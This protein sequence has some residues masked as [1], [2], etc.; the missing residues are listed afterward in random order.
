MGS[1]SSFSHSINIPI[2]LQRGPQRWQNRCDQ[3]GSSHLELPWAVWHLGEHWHWPLLLASLS[4]C[5]RG[6]SRLAEACSGSVGG[7][8]LNPG[9]S[10][11]TATS[12]EELLTSGLIVVFSS[13]KPLSSSCH[14]WKT[15]NHG[16]TGRVFVLFFFF[17][18]R[19]FPYSTTLTSWTK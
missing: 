9:L 1:L 19:L 17:P 3:T 16:E 2:D 8:I 15:G 14:P 7:Y 18:F 11:S 4:P 6:G 10:D 5:Y 12:E 13:M